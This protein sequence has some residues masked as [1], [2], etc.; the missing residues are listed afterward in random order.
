MKRRRYIDIARNNID[1][2]AIEE[3]F[4]DDFLHASKDRFRVAPVLAGIKGSCNISNDHM[5]SSFI[6]IKGFLGNQR[7]I[8]G[9]CAPRGPTCHPLSISGSDVATPISL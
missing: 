2:N 3:V 5:S 7:R 6:V 4:T 1:M 8:Q 9:R